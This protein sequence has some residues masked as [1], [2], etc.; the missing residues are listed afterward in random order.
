MKLPW[1]NDS[2]ATAAAVVAVVA[3]AAVAAAAAEQYDDENDDPEA[4]VA[5]VIAEHNYIP[6]SALIL[7]ASQSALRGGGRCFYVGNVELFCC[8]CH[9][10]HGHVPLLHGRQHTLSGGL[11]CLTTIW[12]R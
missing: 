6:F 2:A 9:N 4:A 1:K 12:I 11:R 3:A 7:Y 10:M 5:S 8:S